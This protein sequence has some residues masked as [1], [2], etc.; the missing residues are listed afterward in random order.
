MNG[1]D[2]GERASF[3][4]PPSHAPTFSLEVCLLNMETA[5]Y[6]SSLFNEESEV[7]EAGMRKWE[8]DAMGRKSGRAYEI[9]RASDLRRVETAPGRRLV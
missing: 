9:R 6:T 2:K 1:S 3:A 4:S 5:L 8:S 7:R